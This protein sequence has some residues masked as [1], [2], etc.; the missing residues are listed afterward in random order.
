MRDAFSTIV[1]GDALSLISG[2]DNLSRARAAS[3][4]ING[5][6]RSTRAE[7][8]RRVRREV[9][10]PA[11]YVSPSKGRL[12]VSGFATPGQLEA[13]ITARGR[14]TSLA[15]F[16]TSRSPINKPGVSVA[17]TPGSPRFLERAFLIRLP[18]IGGAT[19]PGLGN[20]AL[21]VR[22]PRGARMRN[23][24]SSPVSNGLYVL[25]GPSVAQV[26][27]NNAGSGLKQDILPEVAEDLS[28][29]FLRLIERSRNA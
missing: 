28:R 23:K 27:E 21:A 1:E 5:V 15:R 7:L 9:N 24:N 29:E 18:G 22:L 12:S 3:Q 2:L 19:D 6:T 25:Y 10:L 17:V 20:L 8:A 13:S 4:A 26:L 11:S 16:V 14:A